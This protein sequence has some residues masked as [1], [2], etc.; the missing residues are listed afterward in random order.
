[1]RSIDNSQPFVLDFKPGITSCH[2]KNCSYCYLLCLNATGAKKSM[3]PSI[4]RQLGLFAWA[5]AK[6]WACQIIG[7]ITDIFGN[8][9][10]QDVARKMVCKNSRLHSIW[11]FGPW[12]MCIAL[13]Y[14]VDCMLI[15]GILVVNAFGP[16][17][18]ATKDVSEAAT[19]VRGQYC[20]SSYI[21]E[22]DSWLQLRSEIG[23]EVWMPVTFFWCK[24]L[25]I[26]KF[27]FQRS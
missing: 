16:C 1:M 25:E 18:P 19:K 12:L 5:Q 21:A 8:W 14:S 11:S 26:R 27:I 10:N 23:E 15:V 22:A 24:R 7:G 9:D 4:K 6:S 20:D 13:L 2:Y 3:Y 17:P